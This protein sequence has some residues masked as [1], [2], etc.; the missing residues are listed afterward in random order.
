MTRI[1]LGLLMLGVFVQPG[2]SSNAGAA[3]PLL[4]AGEGVADITPP[5]GTEMAGFHR[6]PGQE[7]RAASI[8]QPSS[9]RAL[10]LSDGSTEVALVSLDVCAVSK[11]FCQKVCEQAARRS[12]IPAGNIH[13]SAS[14]THSM[15][16]LKYFHQWGRLP[17]DFA[18]LVAVRVVEAVEAAKRDLGPAE[19]RL[20][21][22]RVAGASGNRTSKVWKNDD[23]FTKESTDDER[24][25]DTTLHALYFVREAPK[26]SLLWYQFSAHPVC[27][28]DETAGPDWPGLVAEKLKRRMGLSPSFLQG[29]C[30]D[31]DPPRDAEKVSD[32]V[33]EALGQAVAH[34]RPLR[35]DAIGHVHLDFEIPLDVERVKEDLEKYRSTPEKC[36]G[37]WVDAA[38]AREYYQSASSWDLGMTRYAAPMTALRLGE[39]AVLLHP[40]ELY[41][42]YGLAIR[43]DS[44]FKETVVVGY[45][46]DLIGYLPDPNAYKGREYS[47]IVVPK[48]LDFPPFTPEA[49]RGLTAAA[50]GLLRKL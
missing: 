6:S 7:R 1:S 23:L 44:P 35:V 34:A 46:D 18:E 33:A 26:G 10:V 36:T 11:D 17:K 19:L 25:L 3:R 39:L 38:F 24:W 41:S 49:T 4:Q 22:A 5:L 29:H 45:T 30:G 31:V 27:F 9:V 13:L 40:G 8:R 16:T 42:Y 15:P 47:A 21:K 37:G 20:G 2:C 48:I 14:H 28:R 43:R 50:L 32:A 12:G